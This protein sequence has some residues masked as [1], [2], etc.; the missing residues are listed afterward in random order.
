MV[1][2]P[3]DP[4]RTI[5]GKLDRLVATMA[6]AVAGFGPETL[7]TALVDALRQVGET[8]EADWAT[9]ETISQARDSQLVR[10]T[11]SRPGAAVSGTAGPTL[12]WCVS[13]GSYHALSVAGGAS[14]PRSSAVAERLRPIGHLLGLAVNRCQELQELERVKGQLKDTPAS[15]VP[16]FDDSGDVD[17]EDIIGESPALRAALSRVQEVAPTDASVVIVGETGTGKELFARAIHTRS[18]QGR[19]PS[20]G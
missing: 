3:L 12:P 8:L 13:G 7:D 18:A 19:D 4:L 16:Q 2:H 15:A 11:W 5:V 9:F 10:R 6:T 20:C 17:F 1:E 14:E